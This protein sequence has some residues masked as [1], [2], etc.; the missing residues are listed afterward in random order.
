MRGQVSGTQ[1]L[2]WWVGLRGKQLSGRCDSLGSVGHEPRSH[3][4]TFKSE[5]C[6]CAEAP[7]SAGLGRTGLASPW[8]AVADSSHGWH[9]AWSC[10]RGSR[11]VLMG[12]CL[13]QRPSH[14]DLSF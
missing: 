6:F 3:P 4:L 11:A 8:A 14:P 1:V 9:P 5:A 13:P 10:P 7:S 2:K 12:C